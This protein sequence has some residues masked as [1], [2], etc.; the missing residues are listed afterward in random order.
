M[1]DL[2]HDLVAQS[3]AA[4]P[5]SLAVKFKSQ[6]RSYAELWRDVQ[7]VAHGLRAAG[8]ARLDRVAVYLPKTLET[9]AALFGTSA[10]GGV[11]VPVN[12]LLK[13]EQVGYIL[14]DCNV[15]LLVTSAARLADLEAT[16]RGCP[17][18]HTVIVTDGGAEE[19]LGHVRVLS[20]ATLMAAAPAPNAA[21]RNVD[22]DMAAILYTSGST[23]RPKGVVLSQRNM[24]T[25]AESVSDYLGNTADDRLLAVLPFS[26]DYGFSQ[27]STAFR[28]GAAVVLMDYLLPKDVISAVARERITGL[29]GVP[30]LWIQLAE[31]SWPAVVS[32]HLRYFT[33]SGGAMPRATL[34]KL[35][36]ALPRTRP[37]LMYGLTEAF[38]ST[39]LPPEDVDRRP[40]S[41]G[42]AIPN[43]E[44]LVVRPD[45]SLC[46]ANEPGELVHRGSLV[47]LGYWNDAAKTAERFKP[48]PDQPQGIV[49]TEMAV[50]SGDTVRR[51]AEGFLYFIGRR[52]EMIKTS[53]YRVSPTEVEEVLFATGMVTDAVAVGV[54]HQLL[55]QAIVVVATPAPGF[56]PDSEKLLAE[57]RSRLPNFM[58]PALV[59]WRSGDIPRN[60]NGKY[61]RPKLAA[62]LADLFAEI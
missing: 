21:T 60:P 11:F 45:G 38:R 5:A 24:V 54:P 25:G 47:A 8:L 46:E 44:I 30:P 2:L 56:S 17:D 40:D 58:V 48:S 51:D 13:P 4:R 3:A 43:A 55:G 23:G 33:N 32:E 52:D 12:P 59:Q 9:V 31:L 22:A 26:F 16:L 1:S 42:K 10:A 39:F 7:H 20:W 41:I 14:R 57:C 50:W 6:E 29:A 49:L 27:M 37:F 34:D 19:S 35:R 28:V 61:D 53:G 18:L 36:Q 15:R 62:E